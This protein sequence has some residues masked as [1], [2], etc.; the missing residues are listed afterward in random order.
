MIELVFVIVVLGILAAIAIPKMFATRDDAIVTK[1]RNDVAA[2]RSAILS[3]KSKRIL[4]GEA[5]Y[6]SVLDNAAINQENQPLFEGNSTDPFF[7]YPIYSKN[8]QGHWM[9]TGNN[10]YVYLLS[11]QNVTFT[12]DP[13]T[14]KFDCN[15]SKTGCQLLTQ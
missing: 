4:R 2:I 7:D 8:F 15:H 3:E 13:T 6:R 12:Y 14:G 5:P 1:G 10:Q 11:D 9:K